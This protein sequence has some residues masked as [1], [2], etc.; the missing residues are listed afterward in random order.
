VD[1]R[2]FFHAT[3][4]NQTC[5]PKPGRITGYQSEVAHGAVCA[6]TSGGRQ[7]LEGK[8]IQGHYSKRSEDLS[9]RS[10]VFRARK[11]SP[12]RFNIAS[13]RHPEQIDRMSRLGRPFLYRRNIFV[14]VACLAGIMAIPQGAFTWGREGHHIIVIVA[15]HYMRPETASRMGELLALLFLGRKVQSEILRFAQN[16][17]EGLRMTA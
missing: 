4:K 6:R 13:S 3:P 1:G 17:S 7:G 9:C 8:R 14:T 16:D 15:E 11:R 2:K 12:V 5:Q 10:A